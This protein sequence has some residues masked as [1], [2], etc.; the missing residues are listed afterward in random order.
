MDRD[1]IPSRIHMR[2]L[3]ESAFFLSLRAEEGRPITA[4]LTFMDK[5]R[6]VNPERR[7]QV[8]CAVAYHEEYLCTVAELAKLACSIDT[9]KATFAVSAVNDELKITGIVN[10][11]LGFLPLGPEF[12]L[13]A[14]LGFTVFARAPGRLAIAYGGMLIGR[15]E[16]GKFTIPEATPLCPGGPLAAPFLKAC[17]AHIPRVTAPDAYDRGYLNCIEALLIQIA[18]LGHGGTVLWVPRPLMALAEENVRIRRRVSVSHS[19]VDALSRT[20]DTSGGGR[21]QAMAKLRS[22]V[23]MLAQFCDV[24]GA[25]LIDDHLRPIG[26]SAKVNAEPWGM[27][28]ILNMARI[29]PQ[30]IALER[31]G[32]RHNSAADFADSVPGAVSLVVSQD[33]PARAM[34]REGDTLRWWPDCLTSV[35]L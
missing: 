16:D 26:Y 6:L 1:P 11:G 23:E 14:P 27:R 13:A 34:M 22:Y 10:F 19:G 7:G 4:R 32:M 17:A 15:F 2:R 25:L 9:K 5:D 3:F 30:L 12:S 24:D 18:Q 29:D 31:L 8:I 20:L 35:F 28:P 21:Q 33:G